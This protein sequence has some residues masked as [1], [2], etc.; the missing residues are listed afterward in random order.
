[1]RLAAHLYI[2]AIFAGSFFE[3]LTE[4]FQDKI[5]IVL[6]RY[7]ADDYLKIPAITYRSA[8]TYTHAFTMMTID[9]DYVW[10][11]MLVLKKG[12]VEAIHQ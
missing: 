7:C 4:Y 10:Y 5:P 2:K 8:I 3:E 6:N 9:I 1:M 12:V 11:Y